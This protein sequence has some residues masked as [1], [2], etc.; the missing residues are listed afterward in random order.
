MEKYQDLLQPKD[1]SQPGPSRTGKRNKSDL[2]RKYVQLEEYR[3]SCAIDELS[4]C[5]Y[6]QK[7]FECANFLRHFKNRHTQVAKAIGLIDDEDQAKRARIIAKK[8]VAI[9]KQLLIQAS[10]KLVAYHN[11]PLGCFMRKG[12]RDIL[13]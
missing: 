1:L 9:D 5:V 10:L 11:L 8:P 4:G 3:A 13:S 2:T 7:K 12:F 6:A